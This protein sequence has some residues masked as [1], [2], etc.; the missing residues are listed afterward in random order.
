MWHGQ[1]FMSPFFW[2]EQHRVKVLISRHRDGEINAIAAATSRSR[3]NSRLRDPAAETFGARAAPPVS[4]QCLMRWHASYNVAH[5]RRRAEGFACRRT[6][7]RP[8][9]ACLG[10]ADLSRR[11]GDEPPHPDE[12]WDRS[13]SIFRSAALPSPS[14]SRS[15]WRRMP[16][17]R[18]LRKHGVWSKPG[19]MQR[20][21]KSTAL[22]TARANT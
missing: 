10:T 21:R 13:A 20:R 15:G 1:H 7:D 9:G 5:H 16:M 6:R 8:A 14:V 12:N 19:S 18:R 17:M 4:R 22:L 11:R 2:R 3:D